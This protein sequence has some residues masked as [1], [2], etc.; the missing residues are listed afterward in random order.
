MKQR[1][2]AWVGLND[3]EVTAHTHH[4]ERGVE[5]DFVEEAGPLRELLLGLVTNCEHRE[6]VAMQQHHAG[7]Q[8]D[9]QTT[10]DRGE[11]YVQATA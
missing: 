1:A 10:R 7:H 8:Q 6:G 4:T 9:A 2:H 11:E 3:S 5:D